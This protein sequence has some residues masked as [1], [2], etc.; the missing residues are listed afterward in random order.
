MEDLPRIHKWHN[1][2]ELYAYFSKPHR[3]VSK[4][5]VEQWLR[6]QLAY[7]V[8]RLSLAI[9]RQEDGEHIGN[10]YLRNIDSVARHAELALFIA[11]SSNRTKGHGQA[12]IRLIV[13]YAFDSLGLLRLYLTAL[14]DNERAINT[15]ERCGFK[16]EGRL[17]RHAYKDGQFKDVLFMGLCVD[18]P[19]DCDA[20]A[21]AV[22]A[23][24]AWSPA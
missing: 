10:L 3:F 2:Q 6:T 14:A 4:T 11:D 5:A 18:K 19:A 12:A 23:K 13:K 8:D 20:A 9:C 24:D 17:C 7:S 16:V 21:G 15:Y 22:A 1:D